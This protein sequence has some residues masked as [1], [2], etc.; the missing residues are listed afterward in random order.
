MEQEASVQM[1]MGLRGAYRT[2]EHWLTDH[3][4]AAT[5]LAMA[6]DAVGV[7]GSA[8]GI[9]ALLPEAG[10]VAI[11][12]AAAAG[13]SSVALLGADGYDEFL[14][15]SADR[16]ATLGDANKALEDAYQIQSL[17]TSDTYRTIQLL[18]PLIALPDAGRGIYS[19]GKEIAT[20]RTALSSSEESLQAARIGATDA[21]GKFTQAKSK[22]NVPKPQLKDLRKQSNRAAYIL[23]KANELNDQRKGKLKLALQQALYRPAAKTHELPVSLTLAGIDYTGWTTPLLVKGM[24]QPEVLP[25]VIDLSG[26]QGAGAN[27]LPDPIGH[28]NAKSKGFLSFKT[29]ISTKFGQPGG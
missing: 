15:V 18:A 6:L 19:A 16:A 9:I 29:L 12:L 8:I 13:I 5:G 14:R 3:P 2:V 21:A 1:W 10:A 22:G 11:G 4:V 7:V 27:L 20:A 17:E 28:S 25:N 23:K 24:N 26:P